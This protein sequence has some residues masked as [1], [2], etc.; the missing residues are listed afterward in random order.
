MNGQVND[1][2]SAFL[3]AKEKCKISINELDVKFP[4]IYP[5][6]LNNILYGYLKDEKDTDYS[7]LR[8]FTIMF[9]TSNYLGENISSDM[10]PTKTET[11][12]TKATSGLVELNEYYKD[13]MNQ[14]IT[15]LCFD[16]LY[17]SI[18]YKCLKQES[19]NNYFS[20]VFIA[21]YEMYYT[22]KT[23]MDSLYRT[24][25]KNW[26][27]QAYGVLS[28]YDICLSFSLF[29]SQKSLILKRIFNE[30]KGHTIYFD[31]DT[32][33]FHHFNEIKDRFSGYI[34]ILNKKV[35]FL[36]YDTE[37]IELFYITAKKKYIEMNNKDSVKFKG[38]KLK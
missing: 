11:K 13:E 20:R 22:D 2:F 12:A 27:N 36:K 17:P 5:F 4:S 30:F 32:I 25:I 26:L 37:E 8:W 16:N 29:N 38:I 28:S 1:V 6:I 9:I 24:H 10:L 3:S 19:R 18:L 31:T 14:N 7:S 15:K 34:D 21:I 35:E 23:Q 33:Y